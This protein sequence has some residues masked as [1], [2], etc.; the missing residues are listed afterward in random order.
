MQLEQ[1]LFNEAYDAFA[2]NMEEI[3]YKMSELPAVEVETLLLSYKKV[4]NQ[5]DG[6]LVTL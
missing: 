4:E 2:G 5:M 6:M 1:I 3:P